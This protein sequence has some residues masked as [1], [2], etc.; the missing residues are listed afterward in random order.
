M[1]SKNHSKLCDLQRGLAT[2]FTLSAM[3]TAM[4]HARTAY[5]ADAE[6]DAGVAQ[7]MSMV[8][9][10]AGRPTSLPTQIPTTIEGIT[11]AQI[12]RSINAVDAEDALK[13]FPS[14]NVR[15][16]Y[17]GDYD[18]AVL[19]SRASGTGNSARSL[20][21]A[22]GILLSNLLG[23]GATFTPRWG[24]VT[25]DEIERVDV[26]Y[27]PFSAAYPG[28]SAGAVV[29]YLTRMPTSLEAHARLSGFSQGFK[30]YGTNERFAGRQGSLSVGN[31][32][33]NLSWW[34]SLSHLDNDGQ[35]ITFANKLVSAG[36][37]G[38]GGTPVAGAVADK[39]PSNADWLILGDTNQTHTVQDHAK[40]KLAYDI[41]PTVRANYTLGWWKNDADRHVNSYL[42]DS[43]GN[44]VTSGAINVAGRTFTLTPADFAPATG[45]L[46]HWMQGLSLKSHT[47]GEWDWELAVSNYDY[48]KDEVRTPTVFLS[49]PGA[50]V[51]TL[52]DAS[53]SG[54]STLAAKG[55]WRPYADNSHIVDFGVQ[56]DSFRLRTLVSN[57]GEWT[58]ATAGTKV[59]SFNG[60]TRLESVY[61]QD[62]W[63]FAQDWKTTIGGRL[64]RWEAYNGSLGSSTSAKKFAERSETSFSPKFALSHELDDNWTVKASAGRAVRYPTVSELFQG[65]IIGDTLMNND[66]NLKPERSVTTELTA[67]RKLEKGLL[68][69]T[70]FHETTHDA[71]YSQ[72]NVN[73]TPNVTNIQNVGLIRTKGLELAAQADDV[74]WTG[75][76]LNASATYTDST[77]IDNPNFPASLGKEQPRVP[78]QRATLLASYHP[79]DVWSV[80]LGARYSGKQ[81]GTLDNSDPNG[82]NYTGVSSY[83]VTDARLRYHFDKQWSASIGIDNIG[84]KKYWAF[85]PYT[86]RTFIAELQFDMR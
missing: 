64:E 51:G 57:T 30:Q 63:R 35:P 46:E 74:L 36:T 10:S 27:G 82:S 12:E 25:P 29:D 23:N 44:S 86:Q 38:K 8:T 55:I 85:H 42:R 2:L 65:A 68:R 77:I 20:V 47:K 26:L 5:A 31:K 52:T 37:P 6:A 43:A 79:T 32:A 19:A 39:N 11:A 45:E 59:S 67:E 49:S 33:G 28:N 34:I 66:P 15:K 61:A 13:Y 21:Y 4:L 3:T 54:W 1:S 24:M 14:L 72:R 58:S 62:T 7:T 71:L 22:D 83:F 76:E 73:V 17:I 75:L 40:I 84:N 69:A 50:K 18:H 53:G 70:Y 80:S 81:W 60:D 16:R 41:T 9:I 56:R 78:K 48:K